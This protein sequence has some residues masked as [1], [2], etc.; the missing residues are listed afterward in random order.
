MHILIISHG[1]PTPDD[2]QYGCFEKDQAL[3]LSRLEHKVSIASVDGR[4]RQYK[5]K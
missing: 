1:Y 3:A 2:P 4:Y 5:R